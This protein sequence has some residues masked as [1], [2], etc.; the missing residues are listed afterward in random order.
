MAALPSTKTNHGWQNVAEFNSKE[1]RQR[2]TEVA[3]EAWQQSLKSAAAPP[4]ATTT[5]RVADFDRRG[6][7]EEPGF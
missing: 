4:A 2:V 1:L 3:L 5:G 7:D 6:P